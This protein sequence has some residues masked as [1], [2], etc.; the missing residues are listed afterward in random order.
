MPIDHIANIH[1]K[2]REW[3][4]IFIYE[5][6]TAFPKLSCFL[7]YNRM[8]YLS[9]L[10]YIYSETQNDGNKENDVNKM[11]RELESYLEITAIHQGQLKLNWKTTML[12][13]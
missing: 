7:L 6:P 13:G 11:G 12:K 2:D 3:S 4:I 9:F 10:L 1:S 8:F 5:V